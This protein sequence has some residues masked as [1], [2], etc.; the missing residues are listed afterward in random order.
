MSTTHIVELLTDLAIFSRPASSGSGKE[1]VLEIM[2]FDPVKQ[3]KV[4]SYELLSGQIND[5]TVNHDSSTNDYVL[6][7]EDRTAGPNSYGS[8]ISKVSDS[9]Q[10]DF[11]EDALKRPKVV[12]I[13]DTLIHMEAH[14]Q[15][16]IGQ[17]VV[18]I[19]IE[20]VA[21]EGPDTFKHELWHSL[22]AQNS[23]T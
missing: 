5:I 7:I 9:M 14:G 16:P 11:S 20:H 4:P 2:K 6:T 13:E 3:T 1:W 23:E 15:D 18:T 22:A 19:K 12:I 17:F 10:Y 21:G 8:H